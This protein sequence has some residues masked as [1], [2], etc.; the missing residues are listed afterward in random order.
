MCDDFDT[1][2]KA[3]WA[4]AV[5]QAFGTAP[6]LSAHWVDPEAIIQVLTPFMGV[7]LNHTMLPGSGG[8]DM[9]S[10]AHSP[11][12]RCLEFRPG[13]RLA[14]TF[15]PAG[16]YFQH[17][18]ESEWNSFFLLETEELPPCG[19]YENSNGQY[20]EVVE[21]SP[22]EYIDRSHWDT[23]VLTHD[24]DGNEIPL[25]ESSRVVSRHMQGK[26]LIVA[27]RSI[28][29]R[30]SA[31]YDGRHNNMTSEQIRQQVQHAIDG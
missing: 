20:E 16:L 2:N 7:N 11:E 12:H 19:V 21:L 15:R 22:G 23:G 5:A 4:A 25:P 31:T 28:W 3:A 1:Q 26:F 27:K 18:P 10:I 29:N 17:F 30:V 9:E 8:L 13:N 6:P 24:E 14:D